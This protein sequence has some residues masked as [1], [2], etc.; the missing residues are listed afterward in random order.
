MSKTTSKT[1]SKTYENTHNFDFHECFDSVNADT[2]NRETNLIETI[3][4]YTN[5][6]NESNSTE[7]IERYK[8]IICFT[9][10]SLSQTECTNLINMA[11][12]IGFKDLTSYSK[13]YR[14]NQRVVLYDPLSADI[15]YNR[16]KKFIPKK[17]KDLSTGIKYKLDHINPMFRFG[18]YNPNDAFSPHKDSGFSSENC[19][20]LLT[21]MFYLNSMVYPSNSG[22]ARGRTRMLTLNKTCKKSE[23]INCKV[24]DAVEPEAGK[25]IIFNQSCI[26]HDGESVGNCEGSKYIMRTDIMFIDATNNKQQTTN[27]KQ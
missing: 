4:Y 1:A 16:L 21:I 23:D 13:G 8:P 15:L 7:Y 5:E 9:I 12:S 19:K 2:P 3:K 20:P 6:C 27:N 25:C 24:L 22:Q 17:I 10:D 11:E 14:D 18:K 26:Y